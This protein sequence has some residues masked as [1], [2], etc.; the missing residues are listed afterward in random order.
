MV[1]RCLCV[2]ALVA[3]LAES[4]GAYEFEVRA[5]TIGQ[6]YELRALRLSLSD[7]NLVRRRFL[8]TLSLHMWDFG[9]RERQARLLGRPQLGPRYSFQSHL[10]LQHDFGSWTVGRL[11][12]PNGVADA[13]DLVPELESEA[14]DLNVLYAFFAAEGLASGAIDVYAGRQLEVNTLDWWSM[15]GV[16]I[17]AHTPWAVSLEAFAG[18][19]VR[20]S[21]PLGS[22]GLEP[23]GTQ[24]GECTEYIEGAVPGSGAWRPI[25]VRSSSDGSVF[26]N[27]TDLCPQREQR[28]PT[29][30]AAI[31]VRDRGGV[32]ARVS[33]R[34]T[35]S[36]RPGLIGDAD[37]FRY[38]D[39]G[40]Y[41]NDLGQARKWGVNE[42]RVAASFRRPF[43]F[44]RG[45][46]TISPTFAA[47]Y[48]ML[49]G[50]VDEAQ[51]G[52]EFRYGSHHVQPEV[53]YS[54]PT[55]D[56]DSI[57]NVFSISPYTDARATYEFRPKQ[58]L[59][60][61]YV[62]GWARW[63]GAED[64]DAIEGLAEGRAAGGAVGVR[65]VRRRH[66]VGRLDVIHEDGYG[67]RRTGAASAMQWHLRPTLRLDGRVS[68]L[69]FHDDSNSK[70]N[71]FT[72]GVQFGA[73]YTVHKGVAVHVLAEE[74]TNRF[75]RNQFRL[76]WV[77]D[78]AFQ[79]R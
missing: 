35:Q 34:R 29:F 73:T 10:R 47:R 25:D 66:L 32:D 9:G 13:I 24:G 51:A 3:G 33:Y 20:D 50:L 72:L 61:T 69:D 42:E 56:G 16:L 64:D 45:A 26:R 30:G 71:G 57:F 67:G 52:L 1:V 19:R 39:L 58:L 2:A 8:Q 54:F 41:P 44:A 49:H 21:S 28:M 53:Y 70:R 79:P 38:R 37:R 77:L 63:Y 36:Q 68:A 48:S 27:D 12:R 14:L 74:N 76:L 46:A 59:W 23:D 43:R 78:L 55:F 4:A 6:G 17:R 75:D 15:D 18:L 5:R 60:A 62:R 65:Y 11:V 22:A 40:Y 7:Q 31:E